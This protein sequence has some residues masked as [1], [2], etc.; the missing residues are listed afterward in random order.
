[1][2]LVT[3]SESQ[4]EVAKCVSAR[5]ELSRIEEG[6]GHLA[7]HI[8][9]LADWWV[10]VETMLDKVNENVSNIRADKRNKLRLVGMRNEWGGIRG[11]YLEY[12]SEVSI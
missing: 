3:F 7:G 9:E 8:N 4:R 1:M 5:R 11:K 10:R 2:F 12:K 6:V